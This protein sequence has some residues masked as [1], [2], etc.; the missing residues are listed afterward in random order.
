[1][2]K[3]AVSIILNEL[4]PIAW[5]LCGVFATW[6][7]KFFNKNVEQKEEDLS[8]FKSQLLQ[9]MDKLT[10]AITP[11]GRNLDITKTKVE[12]HEKTLEKH[13]KRIHKLELKVK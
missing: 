2:D 1:M 7:W 10:D 3:E 12:Q 6:L 9:R 5:V 8:D 13:D 4:E 11:I